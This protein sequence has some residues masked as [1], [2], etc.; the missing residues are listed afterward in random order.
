[1]LLTSQGKY[2]LIIVDLSG[3]FDWPFRGDE[4]ILLRLLEPHCCIYDTALLTLFVQVGKFLC[5]SLKYLGLILNPC[6]SKHR[7]SGQYGFILQQ[8]VE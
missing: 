4:L 7:L 1:M 3:P 2:V 8:L 6:A 5:M